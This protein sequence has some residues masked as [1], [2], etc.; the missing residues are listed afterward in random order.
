VRSQ[1]LKVADVKMI[2]FWD[3]T[4]PTSTR[5]NSA[6]SQKAVIFAPYFDI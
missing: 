5:L 3:I 2:A 6:I 4:P 1:S